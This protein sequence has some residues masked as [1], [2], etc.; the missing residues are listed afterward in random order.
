LEGGPGLLGAA[1]GLDG[2]SQKMVTQTLRTWIATIG[3]P[4]RFPRN[5]PHW[6][7]EQTHWAAL[8]PNH[9]CGAALGEGQWR[10]R[11]GQQS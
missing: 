5:P 7:F 8:Y 9:R 1:S 6:E 2:I 3:N 4:H 10:D 11:A